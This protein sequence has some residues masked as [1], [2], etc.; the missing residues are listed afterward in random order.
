MGVPWAFLDCLK[1][2]P[3]APVEHSGRLVGIPGVLLVALRAFIR[4]WV[5][6][7]MVSR[8]IWEILCSQKGT[9]NEPQNGAKTVSWRAL[10]SLKASSEL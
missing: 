4:F 9:Q 7:G 10:V 5:A 6:L 8:K 3:E 1:V 2:S